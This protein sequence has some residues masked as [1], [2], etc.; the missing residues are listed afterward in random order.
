MPS[1]ELPFIYPGMVW[2]GV[3][4]YQNTEPSRNWVSFNGSWLVRLT[5]DGSRRIIESQG[6]GMLLCSRFRSLTE[7]GWVRI[8]VLRMRIRVPSLWTEN[9]FSTTTG[10]GF[11]NYDGTLSSRTC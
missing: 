9:P 4:E 5:G 3:T 1:H 7:D 6:I 2:D 8:S 11:L 10:Y